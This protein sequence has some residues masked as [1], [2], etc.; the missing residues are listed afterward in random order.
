M[1]LGDSKA[2]V[3]VVDLPKMQFTA[4]AGAMEDHCRRV[5]DVTRS[6][7]TD[8]MG[9]R[10]QIK[11]MFFHTFPQSIEQNIPG[12]KLPQ[13]L[14]TNVFTWLLGA[15]KECKSHAYSQ[16]PKYA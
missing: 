13:K 11:I 1:E 6:N 2:E 14:T 3:E 12:N 4:M 9:L 8:V 15:Y 10:F 7:N 16:F 5:D